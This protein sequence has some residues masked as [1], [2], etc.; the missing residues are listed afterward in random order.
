MENQTYETSRM[1][2]NG[3]H[4]RNREIP[5]GID[6]FLIQRIFMRFRVK[7]MREYREIAPENDP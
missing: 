1:S 5:L 7:K 6:F 4:V 2:R 3:P